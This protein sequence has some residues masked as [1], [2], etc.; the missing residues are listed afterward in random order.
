MTTVCANL[1]EMA[2]DSACCGDGAVAL[3]TKL[4]RIGDSIFGEAGGAFEA[5]LII[6]WLKGKRDRRLLNKMPEAFDRDSILILELAPDGLALWN[7]WGVRMKIKNEFYAIGSGGMSAVMALK[8][9]KTPAEAVTMVPEFDEYTRGP[10][11]VLK[12]QPKRPRK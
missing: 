12:L 11:D 1:K 7:G 8:Q 5:L 3:V 2:A 10:V 6:E 9:G 4:H